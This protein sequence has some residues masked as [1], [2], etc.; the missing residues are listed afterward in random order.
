MCKRCVSKEQKTIGPVNPQVSRGPEGPPPAPHSLHPNPE[1]QPR[2]LRHVELGEAEGGPS[3]LRGPDWEASGREL[4]PDLG[5]GTW[6]LCRAV[7]QGPA[8]RRVRMAG[9]EGLRPR[10]GLSLSQTAPPS[11]DSG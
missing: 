10:A 1:R 2:R 6:A 5:P 4:R 11:S 7:R 3:G 8:C 9:T